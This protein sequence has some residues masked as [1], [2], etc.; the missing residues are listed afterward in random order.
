MFDRRFFLAAAAWTGLLAAAPAMAAESGFVSD[1]ITIV[2]EGEGP[3]VVLIP[4]MT[5]SPSAWRP[6][7]ADMPGYRYHYVQVKGFAGTPA[8]GNAEGVVAAPVAAEIARYIAAEGLEKPALVGHSMGGTMALMI[9]ARHPDSVSRVMVVDQLP[10]MGAVFGPPGTTSESIRPTADALRAQMAA[11]TPEERAGRIEAMTTAM[12]R[13]EAQRAIVR[14][15]G[16][17]SD[18]ETTAN[19]FH[20]LIV[21][22]L[23]PELPAI[24]IPVTVLYVTPAG[25]P[26]TDAQIDAVYSSAYAPLEGAKLVRIPDSAHFIMSDNPERFQAE[27]KAFLPD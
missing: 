10:F 12:V 9:A 24:T 23:R 3:D 19:A 26:L 13:N 11:N 6:S 8:E 5:S 27:M 4:G 21:T 25:V 7:T 17:A 18:P 16:L 2:A 20:E 22:D 14:A 1:R 15:E